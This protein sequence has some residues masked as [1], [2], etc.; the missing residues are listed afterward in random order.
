MIRITWMRGAR[1]PAR[2]GGSLDTLAK[3]LDKTGRN[4]DDG[5]VGKAAKDLDRAVADY[6]R[7]VLAGS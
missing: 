1:R 7:A 6:N 3:N 2:T 5:A 4:R